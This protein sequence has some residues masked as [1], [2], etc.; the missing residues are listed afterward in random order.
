MTKMMTALG[1]RSV[2]PREKKF[3]VVVG[4]ARNLYLSVQPS[5]RRAFVVRYRFNG[6][7][8][9]LT[10]DAGLT[11]A[12]AR[13][14]AAAAWVEIERGVDPMAAKRA[15]KAAKVAAVNAASN[16]V[17]RYAEMFLEQHCRRKNSASHAAQAEHVFR[18]YVLPKWRG[19]DIASIARKDIKE[20]VRSLTLEK[21]RPVMANRTL[22]HL[23]RFFRWCLNEDIITASP[24]VGIE[25]PAKETRR[26]RVLSDAELRQFWA[27]CDRLPV[28]FGDLYRVLLLSAARRSE[29]AQMQWSELDLDARIWTLPRVRSKS[30]QAVALPLGPKCWEI[31][32]RQ[33]RIV[34]NDFV[35]GCKRS[36]FSTI[37]RRLDELMKPTAPW[38]THDLRR[39]ARSAMSRANVPTDHAELC[40]GH[41]LPGGSIR[42]TYDV[43]EFLN[44]KHRAFEA[45]ERLI[46]TI[47]NPRPAK[48][49]SLPRR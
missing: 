7:P 10:L 17:G 33:P 30:G 20:I 1:V 12:E 34:G 42:R 44:E 26:D 11:L 22:A 5:S 13:A 8:S 25:R 36:G 21:E 31:I 32:A 45:L 48:V 18:T 3:E 46:D 29:V 47:I 41:V 2:R 49:I 40:L 14:A 35:W 38:R 39:C 23:S 4:G 9:K 43:H 16:D 15:Q 27:T 24:A 6:R 28:P 37:K 19:R